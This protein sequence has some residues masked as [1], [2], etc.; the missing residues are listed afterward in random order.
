[1]ILLLQLGGEGGEDG[2]NQLLHFDLIH[3]IY[4][5]I[6]ILPFIH[7]NEQ[8]GTI[9]NKHRSVMILLLQL[10]GG[11]ER[12]E[13]I[14]GPELSALYHRNTLTPMY[15]NWLGYFSFV[16]GPFMTSWPV[17]AHSSDRGSCYVVITDGCRGCNRPP[18]SSP[19]DPRQSRCYTFPLHVPWG[20]LPPSICARGHP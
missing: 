18:N 5:Y 20:P 7:L 4:C 6:L 12:M 15:L 3:M 11:R 19:R 13:S 8:C 10:G 16:S 17:E 1:M 9:C 2:I 14:D